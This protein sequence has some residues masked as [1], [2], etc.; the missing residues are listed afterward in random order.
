MRYT[1]WDVLLFPER[2]KIP[3]QEFRTQ[4]CV[5]SDKD[6][7][8]LS[9]PYFNSQLFYSQRS[10][11]QLPVLTCFVPSLPTQSPFRISIH[12]WEKP[13]P[14]RI[15]ESLMHPDDCILYEV[16]V[17]TDNVCVAGT[18]F[19]PRTSWP[20]ILVSHC[21]T[22]V[23]KNGNHELLRFP[24]FHPEVIDAYVWDASETHGRI[25][26]VVSEGFSR[27]NRS[28]PFERV[29]DVVVFSFQHAPLNVLENCGIAWPN[30]YMW[31]QLPANVF[32]LQMNYG[33]GYGGLGGYIDYDGPKDNEDLHGHS[34]TRHD[35]ARYEPNRVAGMTG[36]TGFE[37][38][39]Q[40]TFSNVPQWGHKSINPTTAQAPPP[41]MNWPN[42]TADPRFNLNPT[43]FG[44]LQ[45]NPGFMGS[46]PFIEPGLAHRLRQTQRSIDD[47]SMPDAGPISVSSRAMSS[48]AGMSFEHS[49][50]AS[51]AASRDDDSYSLSYCD[52]MNPAKIHTTAS[53]TQQTAVPSMPPVSRPSA[54]RQARS[55]SYS[56]N[57]SRAVSQVD[58]KD[59]RQIS[60]S[61]VRSGQT[62]NVIET[63]T[64][65]KVIVS[66]KSHVKGKKESKGPSRKS[67]HAESEPASEQS[68]REVS[69]SGASHPHVTVRTTESVVQV[70]SETKRKRQS[71]LPDEVS[72]TSESPTK[73]MS[74]FEKERQVERDPRIEK[75][76]HLENEKESSTAED[77]D[78]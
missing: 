59:V 72:Q 25:R 61:S 20:H 18:L 57:A 58:P 26:I 41:M 63:V 36:M 73:K 6:S 14:S 52:S 10:L 49:H 74:R 53:S 78:L 40:N 29:K 65:R 17:Y 70:S 56:K 2:S 21:A 38:N 77:D 46:D 66:P 24:Q 68:S 42:F 11:G 12:S 44:G 9:A 45:N 43:N 67:A 16:R 54:A 5:V 4:C 31:N 32:R 60:G 1:N 3:I 34:P 33:G 8:Y 64:T 50:Q 35:T 27:P 51:L 69:K 30:P 75:D 39:Y 13:H 28:P 22:E 23:D 71:R 19:G 15:L 37:G 62:D 48:I 55:E 47:I 7:P 76:L